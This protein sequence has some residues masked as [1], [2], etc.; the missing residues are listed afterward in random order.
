MLKLSDADRAGVIGK[1]RG[2]GLFAQ[3]QPRWRA[4]NVA[5]YVN[6]VKS[7]GGGGEGGTS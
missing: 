4:V 2:G 1:H 5:K 3:L 6:I 7:A